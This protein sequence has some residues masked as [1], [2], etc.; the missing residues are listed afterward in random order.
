[1]NAA[2]KAFVVELANEAETW[3]DAADWKDNCARLMRA[4]RIIREHF[5][6]LDQGGE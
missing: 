2:K 6:D 5:E 3:N 4:L 1:M